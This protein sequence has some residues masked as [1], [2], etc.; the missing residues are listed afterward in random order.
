MSKKKSS[1]PIRKIVVISDTHI[2]STKGLLCPGFTTHEGNEIKLNAMQEWLWMCWERANDFIEEVVDDQPYALVLN[3]DLVEG[4]HHHTTEVWSPKVKDQVTAAIQVLGP[5]SAN[6]R[7]TF[8]VNGTECHTRDNEDTIAEVLGA[9]I[10]HQTG[11]FSFERLTLELNGIRHVFRHH[12]GTTI[13]RGLAGTQLSANLAE[14]QV[15]SINNG[16]RIPRVVFCAHRHKFGQYQDN[17]G[18]LV[19]S[20]PWQGLTRFGHKVVSQARTQPGLFILDYSNKQQG[21]LPDVKSRTYRTPEPQA[22]YL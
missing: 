13:R 5:L 1:G 20:P 4:I 7:H 15:E 12:I 21:E 6:A 2:G 3:G 22:V 19:V 16:E 17:N 14:E 8:V 11:N 10:D 18:L 9:E